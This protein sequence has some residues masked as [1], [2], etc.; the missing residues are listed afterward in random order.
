MEVT[1][2]ILQ[3]L[4]EHPWKSFFFIMAFRLISINRYGNKE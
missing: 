2:A 1:Q 4:A 3:F